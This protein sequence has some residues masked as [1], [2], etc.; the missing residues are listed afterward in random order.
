MKCEASGVK[1]E[2]F[3]NTLL[4]TL[5]S[6]FGLFGPSG[7]SGLFDLFGRLIKTKYPH[8]KLSRPL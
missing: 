7:L 1:C 4:L 3:F 6:L 8:C 5:Y 2:E